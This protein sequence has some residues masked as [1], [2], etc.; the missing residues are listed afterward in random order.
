MRV[1]DSI[2]NDRLPDSYFTVTCNDL[3]V[4]SRLEG[5]VRAEVCVIGG[6]FTGVATALAIAKRG[7]KVVLVEQNY[8]GWGASGRSAGLVRGTFGP[9]ARSFEQYSNMFGDDA[10][11]VWGLGQEGLEAVVSNIGTH[12]IQCHAKHG[13]LELY[14]SHSAVEELQQSLESM[15]QHGIH[16][17]AEL[18]SEEMLSQAGSVQ[19]TIAG[20]LHSD[21]LS[22]HPM[23]LVRGEA[24]A[25][26]SY[27]V[28]IFED[29][30][31][32]TIEQGEKT[33]VDTGHGRVTTDHV[34]IAGNGYLGDLVP[35]LS[36]AV[37]PV[38]R[39][40]IVTE[41]ITRSSLPSALS[42]GAAISI[43]GD[44]QEFLTQT[45]DGRL[46][47][48]SGDSAF[49]NHPSSIS[50]ML[51]PKLTAYL[52]Q[53]E[54]VKIDYEWGGYYGAGAHNFP[55]LGQISG[56]IFY[57]QAFGGA[58][59]AAAHASAILLSEKIAG[60]GERFDRIANITHNKVS[61][62]QSMRETLSAIG[63]A[64]NIFKR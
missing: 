54:H 40:V 28:K 20:Y 59:I 2:H 33:I 45:E 29:A 7:L 23:N 55:Q 43:L 48:S 53:L 15:A 22:C 58:G 37:K 42:E 46:V 51:L 9:S 6:G 13:V 8:I 11:M 60:E 18:L 44:S 35:E 12:G 19:R 24:R 16:S 38:G 47:F 64:V 1:R 39:Y 50:A 36:K 63:T 52:S 34:V 10:P 21:W 5:N 49:G 26:E 41:P 27:G 25:A 14:Q 61:G 31:I 30:R 4:F 56:N 3:E 62:W 32:Q 57:A 17:H